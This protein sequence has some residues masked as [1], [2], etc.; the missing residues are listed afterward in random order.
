MKPIR[1]ILLTF[2]VLTTLFT[3]LE[4][5][6]AQQVTLSGHEPEQLNTTETS[7]SAVMSENTWQ[8]FSGRLNVDNDTIWVRQKI[9]LDWSNQVQTNNPL[10]LSFRVTGS[11]DVY[12]DGELIGSNAFLGA[13]APEYSR[14]I[15]PVKLATDGAHDLY[16]RVHA[17]GKKAGSGITLSIYTTS[18][19]AGYFGIHFTVAIVFLLTVSCYLASG[20]FLYAGWV[21]SPR[22]TYL[23]ASLITFL[24]GTLVFLDRARFLTP[25]PYGWQPTLGVGMAILTAG[26]VVA[27][28]GYCAHR[29]HLKRPGVWTVASLF[30][31]GGGFLPIG[32]VDEDT[33]A[34]FLLGLYVLIMTAAGRQHNPSTTRWMAAGVLLAMTALILQSDEKMLFLALLTTLFGVELA[35]DMHRKQTEARRLELLSARLRGDLLRQNIKPHFLMNSLT[36]LMVWI[37]TEPSEAVA[38]IDGLAKEFRLLTGFADRQAVSLGEEIELCEVHLD[39]MSRRLGSS[40]TLSTSDLIT[41]TQIPPAVFHTLIENALSH[42]DYR[43][44]EFE[45]ALAQEHTENTT[46][47]TLT[48]PEHRPVTKGS[49]G[50][51][52]TQYVQSRLEEFCGND[53]RF[54]TD[55]VGSSWVSKIEITKG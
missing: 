24:S 33:R 39:L 55:K 4:A 46:C 23:L 38:F 26:F 35:L 21:S 5:V 53:F 18:L 40:I 7:L 19:S 47:F 54:S 30:V 11:Y 3:S 14:V 31:L 32:H 49:G 15:V 1:S 20:Y 52:G 34:L 45:F 10:A 29:L 28:A 2:A 41:D 13:S 42:N 43:S 16:I 50:G 51:V 22:Q 27:I 9:G 8:S 48:I 36:A 44:G 12:W 6:S 37:E 17:L 25:Y